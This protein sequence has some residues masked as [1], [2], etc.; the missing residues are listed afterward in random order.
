MVDQE[1]LCF[2]LRYL[3]DKKLKDLFTNAE[4][5]C[6]KQYLKQ[7]TLLQIIIVVLGRQFHGEKHNFLLNMIRITIKNLAQS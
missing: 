7:Q 1:K 3:F 4:K 2:N 5:T 6:M